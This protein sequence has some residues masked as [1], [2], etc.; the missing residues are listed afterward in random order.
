M[1][2]FSCQVIYFHNPQY[3][4]RAQERKRVE[5]VSNGKDIEMVQVIDSIAI[6]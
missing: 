3:E 5:N 1:T 4:R 2:F 6:L